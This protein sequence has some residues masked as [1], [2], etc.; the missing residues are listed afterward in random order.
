MPIVA[1]IIHHLEKGMAIIYFE[2]ILQSFWHT[3]HYGIHHFYC[4]HVKLSSAHLY[5]MAY[6]EKTDQPASFLPTPHY[7]M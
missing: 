7:N 5:Q 6:Y 3:F 1:G 2:T 4:Q